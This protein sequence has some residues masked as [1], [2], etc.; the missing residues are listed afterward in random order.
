[1][2][3]RFGIALPEGYKTLVRYSNTPQPDLAIVEY[4]DGG[5]TSVEF[6][7]FNEHRVDMNS[8]EGHANA[9]ARADSNLRR[10]AFARDP[11]DW[12]FCLEYAEGVD[13]PCVVLIGHNEQEFYRISDTFEQ[14]VNK[15]LLDEATK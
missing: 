15:L 10:F 5:A 9:D 13:D 3:G 2:E 11:G 1:M 8:F 7:R 14:F 12:V 6:F 4:G